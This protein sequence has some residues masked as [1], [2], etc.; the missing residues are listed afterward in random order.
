VGVHVHETR[1]ERQF[2]EVDDVR[3]GGYRL[4]TGRSNMLTFHDHDTRRGVFTRPHI[5][6]PRGAEY[7][8]LALLGSS[9]QRGSEAHEPGDQG[10][11]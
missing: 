2:S 8:D 5:E 4:C 6:Q 11:E 3:T 7:D 9:G 10:A 1:E